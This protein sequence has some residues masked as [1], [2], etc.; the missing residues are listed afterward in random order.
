MKY[1]DD[2]F[3]KIGIVIL[4]Y[5]NI[6]DTIECVKSILEIMKKSKNKL[7]SFKIVI[8]DNNSS[9]GTGQLLKD[10]YLNHNEVTVILL[11]QNLGFARGN[12]SGYTHLIET[13][14]PKFI[15]LFNN[16]VIIKDENFFDSIVQKYD[17]D[18]FAVAGP[19]IFNPIEGI[20]QSPLSINSEYNSAFITRQKIV[21]NLQRIRNYLIY[22]MPFVFNKV[23]KIIRDRRS[24]KRNHITQKINNAVI[25]GACIILS[26]QYISKF[27]EGLYEQ[28]FMYYEEYILNFFCNKC[29]LKEIF[30]PDLEVIHL[31]GQS[32]KSVNSSWK[33]GADFK[34]NS[35]K[36]SIKILENLIREE[37]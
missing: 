27:P 12:N 1:E 25:H 29:D 15:I 34:I 35:S 11:K 30:Y 17:M 2:N 31:E 28:T 21:L 36:D 37:N 23:S 3:I 9:N 7:L 24:R 14:S 4:H 33:N 20:Y 26:E 10:Q 13:F 22:R 6:E 19:S 18:G 16:D 32:I 5:N 8:V